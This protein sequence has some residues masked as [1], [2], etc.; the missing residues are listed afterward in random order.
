MYFSNIGDSELSQYHSLV[1]NDFKMT[2]TDVLSSDLFK[3]EEIVSDSIFK[4]YP[5]FY[6]SSIKSNNYDDKVLDNRCVICKNATDTVLS[7]NTVKSIVGDV[8]FGYSVYNGAVGFVVYCYD[9]NTNIPLSD[10][11]LTVETSKGIFNVVTGSDGAI[12][13]NYTNETLISIKYGDNTLYDVT[14]ITY[15]DYTGNGLISIDSSGNLTGTD[16]KLLF[17]DDTI[18]NYVNKNSLNHDLGNGLHTVIFEGTLTSIGNNAFSNC[19][20]LSNLSLSNVESIR[21][22]S[23]YNCTGL[24]TVSL[25]NVESIGN[26]AFMLCIGLQSISLPSV[27]SIGF[28][29]FSEC[30]G[31]Q[32]I[33]LPNVESIGEYAFADC[34][35]LQSISLS[36]NLT[37]IGNIA[38]MACTGL[39]VVEFNWT[40]SETILTYN[41]NWFTGASSSFIFSIPPNTK[42]LYENKG[43]PSNRLIERS[44]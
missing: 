25:S 26:G 10:L 38:F 27:T 40:T 21:I 6:C 37:S 19:T 22:S 20:G 29:A 24:S 31:L 13:Y 18:V 16:L 4:V 14:G 3:V 44:Q 7:F 43:Y 30:S 34:T 12:T 42:A 8:D 39:E 5:L 2:L 17:E 9:T 32:S 15:I 41:S 11:V 36:D 35:S 33:S 23:F 1:C 28:D